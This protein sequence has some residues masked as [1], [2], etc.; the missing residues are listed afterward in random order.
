MPSLSGSLV[1]F[2]AA[3]AIAL[4]A[5]FAFGPL[6]LFYGLAL[7]ALTVFCVWVRR[8]F[9]DQNPNLR[10]K[11]TSLPF[12]LGV[13]LLIVLIALGLSN[14][15]VPWRMLLGAPS[16]VL[17]GFSFLIA[18]AY[19]LAAVF[20]GVSPALVRVAWLSLAVLLFL[21]PIGRE[22][23]RVLDDQPLAEPRPSPSE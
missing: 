17:F 16:L 19:G 8:D 22:P 14:T 2:L 7:I 21:S 20:S 3:S 23:L 18:I 1:A 5:V 11:T 13:A 10:P 6:L 15:A 9:R 4:V 12:G